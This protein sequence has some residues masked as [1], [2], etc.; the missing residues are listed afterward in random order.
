MHWLIICILVTYISGGGGVTKASGIDQFWTDDYKVFDQIYGKTSDKDIYGDSLP[1]SI[2]FPGL[3][4]QVTDKKET[5]NLDY[6][7][8]LYTLESIHHDYSS[9]SKTKKKP[10]SSYNFIS[11]ND[12]KPISQEN[13]PETYN[14]LKHL[15]DFDKEKKSN[16]PT[17]GGFKPFTNLGDP[18]DTEGY[19]SIQDI[20]DAHETKKGKKGND[21]KYLTYGRDKKKKP[22]RYRNVAYSSKLCVSG[23]C[24][25]RNN[26]RVTRPYVRRIKHRTYG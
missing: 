6:D 15:E 24:R 23:R 19:K 18:E 7:K 21:V 9:K 22:S 4:E 26:V 13:D 3:Q 17:Y 12:F 2:T 5:Y 10:A 11:Y 20:L 14:Y 25:K 1:P 16:Q 8:D